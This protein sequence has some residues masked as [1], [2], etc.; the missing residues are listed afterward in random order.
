M[1][2]LQNYATKNTSNAN[3][4]FVRQQS[5]IYHFVDALH[6]AESNESKVCKS[7]YIPLSAYRA[8]IDYSARTH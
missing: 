5:S 3:R 1:A 2:V 7:T 4:I 8:I 6:D